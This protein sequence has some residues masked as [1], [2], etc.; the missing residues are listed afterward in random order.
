MFTCR[1]YKATV[2]L[3]SNIFSQNC[4]LSR[5]LFPVLFW[6]QPHGL[7]N[8]LMFKGL[9]RFIFL[10]PGPHCYFGKLS[11]TSVGRFDEAT[12][13]SFRI[14]V[15]LLK[16][17]TVN[18]FFTAANSQFYTVTVF[19]H[20]VRNQILLLADLNRHCSTDGKFH[21]FALYKWLICQYTLSAPHSLTPH[22]HLL[23]LQSVTVCGPDIFCTG[24]LD[25]KN[26]VKYV[27]ILRCM[28]YFV[29]GTF[30]L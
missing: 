11:L 12:A 7:K 21:L 14:F 10:G 9:C 17:L 18:P 30:D 3:S 8:I 6:L 25:I 1:C 24:Y 22:P 26:N 27:I 5:Q 29:K 15:L 16:P 28:F 2:F 23:P 19:C 20:F 13:S 4:F